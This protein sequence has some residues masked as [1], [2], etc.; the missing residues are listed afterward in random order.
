MGHG[1]FRAY[2]T[3][4]DARREVCALS[5]AALAATDWGE[6]PIIVWDEA[7]FD[8]IQTRI[9]HTGRRLLQRAVDETEDLFLFLEDDVEFNQSLRH[10]LEDWPPIAERRAGDYLFA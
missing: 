9:E 1:R 5:A 2:M 3:S 6:P 8:R 4:C 7:P 10:N